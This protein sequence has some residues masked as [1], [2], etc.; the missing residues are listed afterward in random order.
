MA[1]TGVKIILTLKE[2]VGPCPTP[3]TPT[4]QT[5]NNV[6]GDPDYIAP[7]TDLIACPVV[8]S[9]ECPITVIAT[10]FTNGTAQFEFALKSSTLAYSGLSKVRIRFMNG[11]TQAAAQTFTLPV[12]TGNYFSGNISGIPPSTSF[13]IFIDYLNNVDAVLSACNTGSS[14]ST[15]TTP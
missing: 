1:N 15:T 4:G 5:K 12:Y 7:Y 10:G 6:V 3:C 13:G 8:A 2:V 9:L 14:V 11:I